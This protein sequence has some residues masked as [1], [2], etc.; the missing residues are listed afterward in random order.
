MIFGLLAGAFWGLTFVVPFFLKDFSSEM[1]ALGR[2]GFYALVSLISIAPH[3][4]KII[5][6][7][8]LSDWLWLALLALLGNSLY[9]VL[10]IEAVR[11]VGVAVT[12]IVV[13]ALPVSL[14][15][16]GSGSFSEFKSYWGS[17]TLILI[18]LLLT[19]W[20]NLNS[21][22]WFSPGILIALVAHISW[23]FFALLNTRYLLRNPQIRTQNWSSLIGI[24]SF[25]LLF[26]FVF[27]KT[28]DNNQQLTTVW[29]S[30]FLFW[31]M[32]L[33]LLASWLANW[34]WNEASRQLPTAL[35]GQLI[36]SETIFAIFYES[37]YRR[38]IPQLH[39]S[40]ALFFLIAGVLWA[41]R[42][43]MIF[44]QIVS[45]H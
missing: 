15:V 21:G 26:V 5:T 43:K 3:L 40:I 7:M 32:V 14:V 31:T 24:M 18:G 35:A 22:D 45:P 36:V 13:G 44:K 42:Q 4:K 16:F 9:Y 1:I 12:S 41:T 27:I 37:I 6:R 34:F 19:Q 11:S 17:I 20:P 29:E 25:I 23:L 2:F 38:Q 30:N 33:G 8:Q 28:K 10:M 39:E